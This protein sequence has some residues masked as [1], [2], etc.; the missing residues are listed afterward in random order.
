MFELAVILIARTFFREMYPEPDKKEFYE[1]KENKTFFGYFSIFLIIVF[2]ISFLACINTEDQI[3]SLLVLS[4]GVI[5]IY[6]LP[7]CFFT[8]LR[9]FFAQKSKT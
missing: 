5:S 9:C 7:R 3:T 1:L 6:F 8:F 2:V 4:P